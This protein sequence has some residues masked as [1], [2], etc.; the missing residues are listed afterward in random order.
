M[1][2]GIVQPGRREGRCGAQPGRPSLPAAPS[3]FQ[4]RRR[5]DRKTVE[6]P[7]IN[8]DIAGRSL[9]LKIFKYLLLF[10]AAGQQTGLR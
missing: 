8:I 10:A 1:V 3:L 9:N 6:R 2:V 7:P 5:R 4:L